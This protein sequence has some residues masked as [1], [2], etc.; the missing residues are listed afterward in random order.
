MRWS[1]RPDPIDDDRSTTVVERADEGDGSP[2]VSLVAISKVFGTRSNATPAL[3]RV[4]L[5]VPRGEFVCVLGASGCGKSTMLNIVAGLDRPT[6]GTLEVATER[7]ALMFQEAALFPWLTVQGNVELALKLGGVPKP[8]RKPR[9]KELLTLV[10]LGEFGDRRPHELSGGMRQR[11][12]LARAL[13]QRSDLLLMDEPFG[14]LDA[15][16]RDLLHDELEA[17]WTSSDL[18]VLFVTH[19][20]REAV[21]LGDRVVL[22]S[23]RPGRIAHEYT[24][25]I[26][27]PRRIDSPEVAGLAAEITD[28]L[29]EEVRRHGREN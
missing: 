24:I 12:A 18:T 23:S 13:A 29:R 9:V 22:L 15:M 27:R 16:T 3:D 25:D 26:P 10:N 28:R 8:E 21:R 14:A 17:L 2:A 11:V 20:V 19:N 4:S 5:T 6:A 7:P 1:H